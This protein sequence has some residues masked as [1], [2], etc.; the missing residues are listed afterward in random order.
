MTQANMLEIILNELREVR[1]ELAEA[2]EQIASLQQQ[3]APAEEGDQAAAAEVL[4]KTTRA[5]RKMHEMKLIK[6]LHY[7]YADSN[8]PRY[9]LT[10]L[11]HGCRHGFSSETH[12]REVHRRSRQLE[13]R[14]RTPL[15]RVK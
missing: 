13:Q 2:R 8:R 10:L 15:R 1:L 11:R 4:G 3:Q 7:W 9:D 5:V 6:G 12:L 14:L